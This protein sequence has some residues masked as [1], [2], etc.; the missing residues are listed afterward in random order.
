[1]RRV[2]PRRTW[3]IAGGTFLVLLLPLLLFYRDYAR[4]ADEQRQRL[5]RSETDRTLFTARLR[6]D[7]RI[8]V[9]QV[10]VRRPFE[11]LGNM[12]TPQ[13]CAEWTMLL[14]HEIDVGVARTSEDGTI[15]HIGTDIEHLEDVVEVV[16]ACKRL[17]ARPYIEFDTAMCGYIPGVV[18]RLAVCTYLPRVLSP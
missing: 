8:A 12:Y 14:T 6:A 4:F 18:G 1:M 13:Q 10:R 3:L 16:D 11:L 7:C 15:L 17:S 5:W 9:E 2:G